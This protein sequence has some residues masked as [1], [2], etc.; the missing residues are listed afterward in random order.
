MGSKVRVT[1]QGKEYDGERVDFDT[2]GEGEGWNKYKLEDGTKLKM[3]TVV[4][5][6]V[7]LPKSGDD[8]NPVYLVKSTNIVE[9]DVPEHLRNLPRPKSEVN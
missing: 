5:D 4:S 3:K 7:R 1:F 8:G 2:Q 6:I 9:A